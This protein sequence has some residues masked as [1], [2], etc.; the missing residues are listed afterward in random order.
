[1]KVK[2]ASFKYKVL[3]KKQF[4]YIQ[5][6]VLN[7]LCHIC[8]KILLPRTVDKLLCK[9]KLEYVLL[10]FN[11]VWICNFY[12][13][14]LNMHHTL[15]MH[16]MQ[17]I[18]HCS[19]ALCS[20][21]CKVCLLSMH[22]MH[23]S[24]WLHCMHSLFCMRCSLQSYDYTPNLFSCCAMYAVCFIF[25]VCSAKFVCSVLPLLMSPCSFFMGCT[26]YPVF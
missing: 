15:C 11:A 25:I 13:F 20:M 18:L 26:A 5:Y 14:R 24:L 12:R 19:Y 16:N 8:R 2:I 21:L 7:A 17:R 3:D 9:A 22:S 6:A 4:T 1:V 10:I 23:C